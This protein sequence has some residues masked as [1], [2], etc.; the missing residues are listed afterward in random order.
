[1][2]PLSCLF[3]RVTNFGVAT[4]LLFIGLGFLVVSFTVLPVIGLFIAVPI[5]GLSGIF[6]AAHR[7]KECSISLDN[8]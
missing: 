6:F 4:T 3:E 1:M 5:L 2:N 7:S 8:T